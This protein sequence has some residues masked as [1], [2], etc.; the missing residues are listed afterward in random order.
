MAPAGTV[1]VY[2]QA[3]AHDIDVP[4]RLDAPERGITLIVT[5]HIDHDW[6]AAHMAGHRAAD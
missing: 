5:L 1:T 2:C 4:I 6:L 3:C